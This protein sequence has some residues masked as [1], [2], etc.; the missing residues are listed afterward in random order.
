MCSIVCGRCV[1]SG[2]E[3]VSPPCVLSA[4]LRLS[5]E[6]ARTYRVAGSWIHQL[7]NNNEREM[8]SGSSK[9]QPQKTQKH[10][11][12]GSDLWSLRHSKSDTRSQ[13]VSRSC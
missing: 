12:T 5:A 13:R 6:R 9:A 1:L 7:N 11:A 8:R 4:W 2:S 10:H 3:V